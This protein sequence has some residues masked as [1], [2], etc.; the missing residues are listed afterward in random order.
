MLPMFHSSGRKN[1]AIESV[2]LLFQHDFSLSPRQ[3]AELVWSRFINT[4]G[5][6]G[7]NIPN[8]LHMEHLNRLVKT[9][10]KGLGANK[11]EKAITT[12]G[13]VLGVL[14]PVLENF[15]E[16]NQVAPDSGSHKMASVRKDMAI[17]LKELKGVFSDTPGRQH[18][19]FK[20]PRDPLHH[21]TI[22]E[23]EEY[24]IKHITL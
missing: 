24:I 12:V 3:A 14:G 11:T 19:T 5:H 8:D 1:Y 21:R 16:D 4:Q 13:E 20:K 15:D 6:P 9:A 22:N 2:N 10:M 7:K 17:L 18:K 23:L